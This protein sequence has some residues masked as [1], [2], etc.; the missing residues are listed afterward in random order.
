MFGSDGSWSLA[1]TVTIS[2]TLSGG[3]SGGTV[4]TTTYSLTL[5]ESTLS[6]GYLETVVDSLGGVESSR[7]TER[8]K[9]DYTVDA[10]R[11]VGS[12]DPDD[13]FD[14][15]WKEGNAVTFSLT[16]TR[17]EYCYYNGATEPDAP[18][19]DADGYNSVS[20]VNADGEYYYRIDLVPYGT[21]MSIARNEGYVVDSSFLAYAGREL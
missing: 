2:Y 15:V 12:T 11:L 17:D 19:V 7:Y 10:A 21:S 18:V 20:G 14:D 13:S 3:Q 6:Y 4:D 8:S 5:D 16:M 9:C 1:N